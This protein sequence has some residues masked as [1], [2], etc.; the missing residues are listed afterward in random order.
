MKNLIGLILVF[1]LIYGCMS[2]KE[3][4]NS[5]EIVATDATKDTIK[6]VNEELEYEIIILEIG[7]DSWLVTQR[8]I[9]YY[10]QWV[11][12]SRNYI[13]VTE[14]NQ[15]ALRINYNN[16]D[17][18]LQTIDYNPQIDYGKEVNYLLYMYFKFFEQKYDQ[19]LAYGR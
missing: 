10:S 18:Y 5:D 2:Q 7:F 4:T 9:T 16:S 15:R 11:L 17:L 8:P 12:E 3:V 19:S 1:I 13:Y 14:W 6:I